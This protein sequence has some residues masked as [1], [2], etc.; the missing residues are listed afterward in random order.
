M[1]DKLRKSGAR[2]YRKSNNS[3][4]QKTYNDRLPQQVAKSLMEIM[5]NEV[6]SM[7]SLRQL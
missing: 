7:L 1:V 5:L 2:Q 3:Q 6:V 4:C